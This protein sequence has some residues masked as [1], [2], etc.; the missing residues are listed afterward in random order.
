MTTRE[1]AAQFKAEDPLAYQKMLE[2]VFFDEISAS[3]E[4]EN[5]KIS[6]HPLSVY[7]IGRFFCNL[8]V[9]RSLT[10]HKDLRAVLDYTIG[11]CCDESRF[12]QDIIIR[13]SRRKKR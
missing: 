5:G 10:G 4:D 2:D 12:V 11:D 9:A 8:E 7:L 6:S 3:Y 13:D 1:K